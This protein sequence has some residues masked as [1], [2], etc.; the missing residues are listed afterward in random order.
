MFIDC[1]LLCRG[2][3]SH[4]DLSKRKQSPAAGARAPVDTRFDEARAGANVR[5]SSADLC[6]LVCVKAAPVVFKL[7]HKLAV[8]FNR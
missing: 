2:Y 3:R 6:E 7:D 8:S 4:A 1:D 5:E